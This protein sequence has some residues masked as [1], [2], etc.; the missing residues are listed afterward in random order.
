MIRK[1]R[2]QRKKAFNNTLSD[3]NGDS[4]SSEECSYKEIVN[5][6]LITTLEDDLFLANQKEDDSLDD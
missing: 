5:L 3:Y 6:C 2:G 4:L 1:R